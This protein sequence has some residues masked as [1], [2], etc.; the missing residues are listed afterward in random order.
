MYLSDKE[1]RLGASQQDGE[2]AWE[3]QGSAAHGGTP[4]STSWRASTPGSLDHLMGGGPLDIMVPRGSDNDSTPGHDTLSVVSTPPEPTYAELRAR[5]LL[6]QALINHRATEAGLSAT[7]TATVL[8]ALR[9][10]WD[11]A[12]A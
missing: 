11:Q 2:W 5:C 9:G 8:Y 4:A 12:V 3:D 6:A 7:A 1:L 10:E